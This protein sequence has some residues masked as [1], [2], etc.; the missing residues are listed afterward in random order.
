M[1][2]TKLA[3]EQT[4]KAIDFSNDSDSKNPIFYY[5]DFMLTN[6]VYSF[7]TNKNTNNIVDL[8]F[9]EFLNSASQEYVQ[10][11]KAF[12]NNNGNIKKAA[13]ELHIHYNTL[14]YRLNKINDLYDMNL[15]N[16]NY[17]IRLKLSYIALEFISN[18]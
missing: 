3:Y 15:D 6:L 17:I 18:T 14:K 9:I 1:H 5:S 10:T 13:D 8:N 4:L 7:L 12:I 16:L 11:L 2:N